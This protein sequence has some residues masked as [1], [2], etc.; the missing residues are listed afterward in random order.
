MQD[1]ELNFNTIAKYDIRSNAKI[2][3][4]TVKEGDIIISAKGATIKICVIPKHDEPLL[5]SQ[6][7]I[8]IR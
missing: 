6:N 5:I 4:Y 2:A 1:G 3:S 7:F 8:G